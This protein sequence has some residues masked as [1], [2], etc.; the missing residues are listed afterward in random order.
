MVNLK[1]N[2][3]TSQLYGSGLA[4][5]LI[6][7]LLFFFSQHSFWLYFS[8]GIV[9]LLMVW[10][11]PFRYFAVLWLSFGELLGYFVSRLLLSAIYILVV[12]PI[13]WIVRKRIRSNMQLS[14]FKTSTDSAFKIRNH[15]FTNND[16]SKPF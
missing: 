5:I 4:A 12:V 8:L 3:D 10:P 2:I 1:K 7:L 13:G 14:H 9:L 15:L 16:L 11:A 6:C